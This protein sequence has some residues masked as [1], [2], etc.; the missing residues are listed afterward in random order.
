MLMFPCQKYPIRRFIQYLSGQMKEFLRIIRFLVSTHFFDGESAAH[1]DVALP[2][3]STGIAINLRH[4]LLQSL[5]SRMSSSQKDKAVRFSDTTNGHPRSNST[6]TSDDVAFN[7]KPLK[8][9][10]LKA[11]DV[12]RMNEDELDDVDEWN[13]D[14]DETEGEGVLN[15]ISEHDLIKAKRERRTKRVVGAVDPIDDDGSA[16][17]IDYRTSLAAE[18]IQVEPFNMD[19]ER[20]DGSGYFDGDTYIFRKRDDDNEVD[21]WVEGLD[22]GEV[23]DNDVQHSQIAMVREDQRRQE[24]SK[25]M[26]ER[27]DN[28]TENDLYT[29]LLLHLQENETVMSALIRFG[30]MFQTSKGRK[31]ETSLDENGRRLAQDAFNDITEASSALLLKG[32]IDIYELKRSDIE[33]L[34][35][36][37]SSG[38][39][40]ANE[41][42]TK[43]TLSFPKANVQ[44][45]YKGNHDGQI[46]GPFTTEEM[47]GWIRVGY[48][49]GDTAVQVR[50]VQATPPSSDSKSLREDLLS[51][52]LDDDAEQDKTPQVQRGEWMISDKVDFVKYMS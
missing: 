7:Q 32:K 9:R 47:L 26:D 35:S 46:H 40:T 28:W 36:S 3:L 30:N 12:D 37:L 15:G 14:D 17:R 22:N 11:D 23:N 5:K 44:W 1:I 2:L 49:V 10:K 38:N 21:A 42:A 20:N 27:M 31:K 51:D 45:E 48:F 33:L 4:S 18:G 25:A 29:K 50:T 41:T 39:N 34:Q 8:K 43:A 24:K 16:T 13:P 52:L 6:M 19:Q